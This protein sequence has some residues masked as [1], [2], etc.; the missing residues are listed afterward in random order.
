MQSPEEIET[1]TEIEYEDEYEYDAMRSTGK[2]RSN[3]Y[4]PFPVYR[5]VD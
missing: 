2:C 4:Y 3:L 5:A 1:D